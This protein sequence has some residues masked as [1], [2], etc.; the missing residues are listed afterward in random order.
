MLLPLHSL[1]ALHCAR[2]N[3]IHCDGLETECEYASLPGGCCP[4]AVLW[5]GSLALGYHLRLP[6]L[7]LTSFRFVSITHLLQPYSGSH[8]NDRLGVAP[9]SLKHCL[10]IPLGRATHTAFANTTGA[11]HGQSSPDESKS[12][13]QI[14]GLQ[15]IR[16]QSASLQFLIMT[17]VSTEGCF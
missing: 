13:S 3:I 6:W 16:H 11:D 4:R 7:A 5:A 12:D 15:I 10:H 17:L 14:A 1:I 9:G 2:H 8:G